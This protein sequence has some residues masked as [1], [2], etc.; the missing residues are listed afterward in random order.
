ML[1]TRS[2][3]KREINCIIYLFEGYFSTTVVRSHPKRLWVWARTLVLPI[4]YSKFPTI[5]AGVREWRQPLTATSSAWEYFLEFA[6]K[7]M[8]RLFYALEFRS[9]LIRLESWVY[10]LFD[11]LWF[12]KTSLRFRFIISL[13]RDFLKKPSFNER[14]SADFKVTTQNLEIQSTL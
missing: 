3:S 11:G 10:C 12:L 5:T 1:P 2:H 7:P 9:I 13:T 8:G 14:S 4:P 6:K